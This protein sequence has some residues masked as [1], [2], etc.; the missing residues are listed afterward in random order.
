MTCDGE[1][2]RRV[3]GT[4]RH[5]VRGDVFTATTNTRLAACLH[6]RIS[7]RTVAVGPSS[8][9]SERMNLLAGMSSQ[10]MNLPATW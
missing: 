2:P 8:V 5:Q 6:Q 3:R 1:H 9:S 10:R 7:G 4:G